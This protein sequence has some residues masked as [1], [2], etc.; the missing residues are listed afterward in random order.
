MKAT[1]GFLPQK[2]PTP[3]SKKR[4][5]NYKKELSMNKEKV[6]F[7]DKVEEVLLPYLLDKGLFYARI[8]YLNRLRDENG[9]HFS[10]SCKDYNKIRDGVNTFAQDDYTS[11]RWNRHYQQALQEM[12]ENFSNAQLDVLRYNND[13]DIKKALPKLDTHAGWTYI[14]TGNR[15]KGA[16]LD[17]VLENFEEAVH[18]ACEKGSF[19]MPVYV[20]YRTQA[21][22]EFD[23]LTSAFTNKCKL[24]TR[25]VMAVAL[26]VII[27]ELMFAKPFQR[28]YAQMSTYVGGKSDVT[29][30]Q[31]I[32][33][34]RAT[35]GRYVSLD[36]S[37]YDQSISSWLIEDAF[38]IIRCA[39]TQFSETESKL[40]DVVIH[41]FIHKDFALAEGFVHADKGVPSGSMFTQIIDSLVNELMIRTFFKTLEYEPK[42]ECQIM[43]DDNLI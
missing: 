16:N 7:D 19:C 25:P 40:W 9:R 12:K 30:Q 8:E 37:H 36:Y 18:M 38:S 13:E 27:A 41:D 5:F 21:S 23:D 22:G 24:K 6:V 14:I 2:R 28:Y 10:R 33:N 43:G 42:W 35:Y 3:G 17:N 20:A 15:S 29:I 39:F 34:A 32:Q 4:L 11:F 26:P 31:S 1:N